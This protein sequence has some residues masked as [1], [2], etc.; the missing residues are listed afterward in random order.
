M[1]RRDNTNGYCRKHRTMSDMLQAGRVSYKQ[2]NR[3]SVAAM[4]RRRRDQVDAI[5]LARGC[6]DCGYATHAVALDFDHLPGTEKVAH[7]S[8]MLTHSWERIMAEID[9]CVVV[10][11]NCHRV[12]TFTRAGQGS[13]RNQA[14]LTHDRLAVTAGGRR[15]NRTKPGHMAPTYRTCTY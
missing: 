2:A 7:V 6:I 8:S 15:S 3:E 5:K 9:K 14:A 12:R 13:F 10:C 4:Q 11:A 1:L